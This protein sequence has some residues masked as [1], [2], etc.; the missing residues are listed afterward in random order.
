MDIFHWGSQI[1]IWSRYCVFHG[2]VKQSLML[3]Q[4]DQFLGQ[5]PISI[6]KAGNKHALGFQCTNFWYLFSSFPVNPY[7]YLC[8]NTH[9]S[10]MQ[11]TFRRSRL[12]LFYQFAEFS[13]R[14]SAQPIFICMLHVFF[15]IWHNLCLLVSKFY[16]CILLFSRCLYFM[17]CVNLCTRNTLYSISLVQPLHS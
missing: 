9:V 13:Y 14:Y 6:D 1:D 7:L 3:S 10:Y 12:L 4:L 15:C 2:N 8:L 16:S 11:V 17:W 5:L